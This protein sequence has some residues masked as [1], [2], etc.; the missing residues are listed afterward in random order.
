MNKSTADYLRKNLN[1]GSSIDDDTILKITNLVKKYWC[2]FVEENVKIPIWNYE[3]AIDT[4]NHMPLSARNICYGLHKTP[5]IQKAIDRLSHNDQIC[6]VTSSPWFSRI[7]LAPKSHQE[8]IEDISKC[9]WR[10]CISYIPLNQITRILAYYIPRCDDV[11]E[12]GFGRAQYCFLLDAFTGYHQIKMEPQSSAKTA[13]AGPHGRKYRYKVMPYGIV[14]GPTI[15]VI[16]IYNMKDHWDS[17]ALGQFKMQVDQNNNATIII[18]DTFAYFET[19]EKGLMYLEDILTVCRRYNLTWKLKKCSFFPDKVD[20]VGHD[21]TKKGNYPASSKDTLLVNWQTP[22]MVRN[23]ASFVGF[24]NLYSKY[25][26]YFEQRISP[27]RSIMEEFD[28]NHHLE[29]GEWTKEADA[30]F[31]DIRNSILSKPCLQ[32]ISTDKGPYLLTDFSAISLGNTLAQPNDDPESIAVMKRED[33][34]GQC[35][36]NRIL[37][38][39]RLQPCGVAAHPT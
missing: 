32:R 3:C 30:A 24:R 33:A 9:V 34:G 8:T 6:I 27:L 37:T 11:V 1:I 25:I 22:T 26:P 35:E 28:Y 7:I 18:D 5:I 20:F 15:Y 17:E 19:I 31:H 21:L 13:F 16:M 12:Y 2:C 29:G 36:F 10:F 23:I 39:L 38:G 4:G 14:N